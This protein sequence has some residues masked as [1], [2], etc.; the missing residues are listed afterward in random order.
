MNLW[1]WISL[2]VAIAGIGWFGFKHEKAEQARAL[3]HMAG[4]PALDPQ[5]FGDHYFA[6]SQA[7]IGARLR[8]LLAEYFPIDL[9]SLH[10]DDALVDDLRMDSFDSMA[11]V[12]FVI[13][14]EKEFGIVIPNAAAKDMRTLRD[15]AD[16]V[17]TTLKSKP[18]A[19]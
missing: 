11:T 17:A 16:F 4:R 13:A 12:E 3:R 6:S 7:A 5:Q 14:I 9:S 15:I 10:P 1:A 18:S 8:K 19:S 2:A